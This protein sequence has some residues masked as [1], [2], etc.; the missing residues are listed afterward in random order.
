VDVF[1][2]VIQFIY[3][4]QLSDKLDADL[5][6]EML[7]RAWLFGD[8]DLVPSLQNR[9][10]SALIEKNT[11][12]KTLPTSH[13][14][15]IYDN[16]ITGSPLRKI[17]VDLA[18]YRSDVSGMMGFEGGKRWP[19]EALVDLVKALAQKKEGTSKIILPEASRGKC[20]YHVHAA[21][22]NCD[23]QP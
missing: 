14:K 22:E 23:T 9:V 21:G 2:V 11:K 18:A 5:D 4:R 7:V 19:H 17:M 12:T 15:F 10:M 6:W 1:T 3:T 8:K 16:T 13:L 20:Q